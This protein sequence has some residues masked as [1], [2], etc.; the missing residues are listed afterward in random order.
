MDDPGLPAF[1]DLMILREGRVL[2]AY[3]DTLGHLTVGIGH[4]VLPSDGIVL[5]QVLTD[6][7]VDALF[8]K[9]AASALSAARAQMAIAGITSEA[10]V[11]YLAS[12]N[13]QLGDH[14]TATFPNTWRTICQGKYNLAAAMVLAS[15]WYHET[16]V[17]VKDLQDALR[18]LP[19]K[20]IAA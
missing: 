1:R 9:D 18:A 16:P 14:W 7:E 10:F 15:E 3:I 4:L 17:R 13:F 12:V 20:V 8:A 11:P 5:G 2:T 19:T 6:A